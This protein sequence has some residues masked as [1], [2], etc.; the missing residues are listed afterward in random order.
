MWMRTSRVQ[1][2]RQCVVP[3]VSRTYHFGS[4]RAVNVNPYFQRT[5]FGRHAFYNYNNVA[6]NEMN[7]RF[8]DGNGGKYD[9]GG[10]LIHFKDIDKLVVVGYFDKFQNKY[11]LLLK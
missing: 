10:G 9:D 5:Y 1:R 8:S 3:E 4:S 11:Y 6:A 2:G 7:N